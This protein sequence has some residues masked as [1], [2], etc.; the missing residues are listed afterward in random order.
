MAIRTEV[1]CDICELDYGEASDES[2]I[3][4]DSQCPAYPQLTWCYYKKGFQIMKRVETQ[5][6]LLKKGF[7][8]QVNRFELCENHGAQFNSLL[9]A[10]ARKDTKLS[11]VL[12][13]IHREDCEQWDAK[14][15]AKKAEFNKLTKSKETTDGDRD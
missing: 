6:P 9:K 12:D 14:Q 8:G 5:K 11:E 15:K 4:K 3:V 10:F 2:L 1:F 7:L 13:D